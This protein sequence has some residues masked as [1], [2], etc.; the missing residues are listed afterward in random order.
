MDRPLII[1]ASLLHRSILIRRR[2]CFVELVQLPFRHM[3]SPSKILVIALGFQS[4][5]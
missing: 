5:Y 1:T 4:T 3:I 2:S